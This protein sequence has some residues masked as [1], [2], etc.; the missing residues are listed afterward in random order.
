ME[1]ILEAKVKFPNKE[2]VKYLLSENDLTAVENWIAFKN[3]LDFQMEEWDFVGS[4]LIEDIPKGLPFEMT[5]CNIDLVHILMGDDDTKDASLRI[6]LKY[7]NH[8]IENATDGDDTQYKVDGFH[9]KMDLMN[10]ALGE[11]N[12]VLKTLKETIIPRSLFSNLVNDG[13]ITDGDLTKG[14][15]IDLVDTGFDYADY[16]YP[17]TADAG[18]DPEDP[19]TWQVFNLSGIEKVKITV[20][21][22]NISAGLPADGNVWNI[23]DQELYEDDLA[24]EFDLDKWTPEEIENVLSDPDNAWPILLQIKKKVLTTWHSD[25]ILDLPSP[26]ELEDK[27]IILQA[28]GYQVFPEECS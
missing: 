25:F 21:P 8:L 10:P 11:E 20:T 4:E 13:K 18:Y 6:H 17:D 22:I 9:I 24:A 2:E 1:K 28:N 12:N 23:S 16:D 27:D 7:K 3:S 15:V 5:I 26:L 14:I 19:S